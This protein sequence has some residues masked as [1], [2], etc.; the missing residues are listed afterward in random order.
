MK[1]YC[2]SRGDPSVGIW[3]GSITVDIEGFPEDSLD[4]EMLEYF[5][6]AYRK[7]AEEFFDDETDVYTEEEVKAEIE[8]ERKMMLAEADMEN[9]EK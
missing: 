8:Y 6:E 1:I 2:S 9:K 3:P 7:I 4:K 5:K